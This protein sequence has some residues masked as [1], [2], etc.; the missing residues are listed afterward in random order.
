MNV[1]SNPSVLF[2]TISGS[3]SKPINL[4]MLSMTIFPY[5]LDQYEIIRFV[6]YN[7]LYCYN[8]SYA[9]YSDEKKCFYNQ[10]TFEFQDKILIKIYTNGSFIVTGIRDEDTFWRRINSILQLLNKKRYIYENNQ[11]KLIFE[12]KNISVSTYKYSLSRYS[13]DLLQRGYDF[14]K[15]NIYI[16][17]KELTPESDKL[18]L[19]S[20]TDI[21]NFTSVS[22]RFL[23]I[24]G[25]IDIF[26]KR[27][28]I[29]LKQEQSDLPL[30]IEFI[31]KYKTK[32][33]TRSITRLVDKMNLVLNI[34]IKKSMIINKNP[35]KPSASNRAKER[36]NHF[37]NIFNNTKLSCESKEQ[38]EKELKYAHLI[39][40]EDEH[41]IYRKLK[42]RDAEYLFKNSIQK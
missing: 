40:F 39:K 24:N 26:R 1:L 33:I 7:K 34:S 37:T 19:E 22:I 8:K 42:K 18:K 17:A 41:Y 31:E 38:I 10:C 29:L 2:M 21:F 28:D 23:N 30:L 20:I 14:N 27:I 32:L 35:K 9:N 5:Q 11:L 36:D 15:Y 3:F 25:C 12:N 16:L 6:G 4:A 13:I